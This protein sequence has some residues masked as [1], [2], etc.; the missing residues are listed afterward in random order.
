MIRAYMD[1]K[2]HPENCLAVL[3][4]DLPMLV[5]YMKDV[6][7]VFIRC[8]RRFEQFHG[9]EPGGAMGLTDRDLHEAGIADR[10][11]EEDREVM[12]T[13][14]PSPSRTWMVPGAKGVLRWWVSRKTPVRDTD[15]KVIGVA[16]VM[17]EISGAAGVTEPFARIEPALKL[18]HGDEPGTLATAEL[19]AACNYSE[20]Q[21]NRVFRG[22]MGRSPR[23]YVLR[24]RLETAK[25]LLARTDLPLSHIAA[26][27]GFYDA[28][29]FGKRFREQEGI[30][31]RRYRIR[32]RETLR[33]PA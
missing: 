17:Y 9:L 28:S 13:G 3:F 6:D 27:A 7:G 20:S 2:G 24:H 15:G 23:R 30:T 1:K 14:L 10:Y 5:F 12:E 19:A 33:S 11:R 26:R 18:I 21:F 4:E 29:D 31:P 8:N 32:L 25:D 16:G 22:I